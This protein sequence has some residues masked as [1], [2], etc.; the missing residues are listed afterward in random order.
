MTVYTYTH[1][2]VLSQSLTPFQ[3]D[4][5]SRFDVLLST[6]NPTIVHAGV[7]ASMHQH[8][9]QHIC[10]GCLQVAAEEVRSG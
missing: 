7:L 2:N 3:H 6:L 10:L 5:A 1:R 4:N 8:K 9:Q